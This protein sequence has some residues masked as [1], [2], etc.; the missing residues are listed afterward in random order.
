MKALNPVIVY[1]IM[2]AFSAVHLLTSFRFQASP[3]HAGLRLQQAADLLLASS[4]SD[5][6][7]DDE[8]APSDAPNMFPG[9]APTQQ[10][11]ASVRPQH[12]SDESPH[13]KRKRRKERKKDRARSALPCQCVKHA[14]IALC[15]YNVKR[16]MLEPR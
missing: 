3:W 16:F 5:S 13:R 15:R 9:L 12:D 10:H 11:A 8:A 7:P 2:P 6:E 1:A 14:P 4:S